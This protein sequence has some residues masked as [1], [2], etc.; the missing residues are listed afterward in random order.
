MP[1]N[2]NGFEYANTRTVLV[3]IFQSLARL[4][5]FRVHLQPDSLSCVFSP[6]CGMLCFNIIRYSLFAPALCKVMKPP[7]SK[8]VTESQSD[9]DT[10]D[11]AVIVLELSGLLLALMQSAAK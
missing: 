9:A 5:F 3:R 7:L 11:L 10:T 6:K 1:R 8:Q 4:N 2:E